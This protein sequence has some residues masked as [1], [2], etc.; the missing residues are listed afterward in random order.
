[1][2]D[3]WRNL[4]RI[5]AGDVVDILLVTSIFYVIFRFIRGTR[6]TVPLRG[7]VLLVA[8][9]VGIFFLATVFHLEGLRSIFEQLG[10][11]LVL[12]LIVVFQSD[13]RRGLA[14]LGRIKLVRRL[15]T[16]ADEGVSEIIR[17]VT[18]MGQRRVGA[19]IA[20]ERDVP[21]RPWIDRGTA[22]EAH[23]RADTLRTIFTVPSPL[24]DGAVIIRGERIAAAACILP[25]TMGEGLARELGT[26]HRAALGL[27]EETDAVIIVVSEETGR[28]SI[29]VDGKLERSAKAEQLEKRLA[30][31]L[32]VLSNGS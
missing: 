16:Q 31:L 28:I 3:L 9:S 17:A 6:T 21:L 14:E 29:A 25:L 32:G 2:S 12:M 20:I 11:V 8:A 15:F 10:V 18:E 24:H 26:R 4:A 19:L 5:D 23:I 22:V 7:F 13:L 1:M 27:S 30:E